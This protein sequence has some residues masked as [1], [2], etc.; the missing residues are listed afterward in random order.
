LT[1]QPSG[2]NSGGG[3]ALQFCAKRAEEGAP[4]RM[5]A[6]TALALDGAVVHRGG[7]KMIRLA[8]IAALGALLTAAAPSFATDAKT[9]DSGA[10]S[11]A[12]PVSQEAPVRRRATTLERWRGGPRLRAAHN[13]MLIRQ[14]ALDKTLPIVTNAPNLFAAPSF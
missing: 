5:G 3:P 10:V 8:T 6:G 14:E 13:D 1:A 12:A 11:A 7:E 9:S 4:A 2:A